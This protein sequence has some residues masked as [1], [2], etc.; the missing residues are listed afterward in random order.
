MRVRIGVSPF[1]RGDPFETMRAVVEEAPRPARLAGPL[2]PVLWGLLEKE[3]DRRWDVDRARTALRELLAGTLASELLEVLG[4]PHLSGYLLAGIVAC[5]HALHLV[6]HETVEALSPVNTLALA[7]IA[8]GGG[9][10]LRVAT[11]REV[12][13]SVAYGLSIQSA[14]GLV[15]LGGVFLLISGHVPFARGLPWPTLIAVALLATLCVFWLAH[16]QAELLA[17]RYAVSHPLTRQERRDALRHSWPMVQAGFPPVIGL[18]LGTAGLVD[19][20]GAVDIALAIGVAELAAWGIAI[21]RREQLGTLRTAGVTAANVT[22]GL[23]VVGL[24]LMIH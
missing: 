10:E 24:K 20:S 4:L 15:T 23:A 5:P 14:V 17:V 9:A 16:T 6:N 12:G 8:L 11:L 7:L 22:L 3:P 13:R 19:D 1:D 18:L 21:G 2:K